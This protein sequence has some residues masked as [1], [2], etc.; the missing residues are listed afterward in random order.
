MKLPPILKYAVLK[1][2]FVG[3]LLAYSITVSVLLILNRPKFVLLIQDEDGIREVVNEK[4]NERVEQFSLVKKY[5]PLAYRYNASN[6]GQRIETAKKLM[7]PALKEERKSEF[8]RI[9][10]AIRGR[11]L[12]ECYDPTP[13]KFDIRYVDGDSWEVDLEM[14]VVEGLKERIVPLRLNMKLQKRERTVENWNAWEIKS[15]EEKQGEEIIR[16]AERPGIC[17]DQQLAQSQVN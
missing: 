15:Y 9:A 5:L 3:L 13:G 10:S 4:Q 16:T 17:V 2:L 6:F 7:S 11:D 14:H 12:V 1:K 8:E